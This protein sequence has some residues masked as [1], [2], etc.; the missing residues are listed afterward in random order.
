MLFG[1]LIFSCFVCHKAN[2]IKFA[3]CT[4]RVQCWQIICFVC[5]KFNISKLIILLSRFVYAKQLK[6]LFAHNRFV[7]CVCVCI[8][9]VENERRCRINQEIDLMRNACRICGCG[10]MSVLIVNVF[11]FFSLFFLFFRF[12]L[13]VRTIFNCTE[14]R[15][16]DAYNTLCHSSRIFDAWVRCW[17]I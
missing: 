6:W 11:L 4:L 9:F 5:H 8:R 15:S 1:L 2:S 12:L 14:Y 17:C 10:W 7:L 3:S 13:L 16:S